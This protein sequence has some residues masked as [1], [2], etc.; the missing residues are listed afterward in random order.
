M[1]EKVHTKKELIAKLP[2]PILRDLDDK[3]QAVKKAKIDII[4][5]L[6]DDPT[7]TQTVYNI[8]VLTTWDVDAIH[9][10]MKRQTPL[11]FILT[12]SRSLIEKEAIQLATLIGQ[13]IRSIA[14]KLNKK[15]LV[16][17]RSDS[18]LRGHYPAEVAALEKGLGLINGV[19]FIVPAFFEGGRY[20]IQDVHYVEKGREMIPA[21]QT[22][23]AQ[24]KV[25]GFRSSNLREWVLEKTEEAV[26]PNQIKSLSLKELRNASMPDLITK[27][28]RFKPGEI[29]IVNA[30][31]YQDLKQATIAILSSVVHPVF[32]TAASFV[33]ALAAQPTKIFLKAED[34]SLSTNNGG[35]IVVGSY[36]PKSTYQ[37]A[38]LQENSS[39]I[40]IEIDVAKLLKGNISKAPIIAKKIS[41]QLQKGEDVVLFTSRQLHSAHSPEEN[42]IIGEKVSWYL[43]EVVANLSVAPRYILAK[44]GI[45]SSDIATRGLGVK[46]AMVQGQIIAG[47]PVWQLGKESKFPGLAYIVFPGNVGDEHSVSQVVENLA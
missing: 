45:T 41:S 14:E 35:L 44:G 46:R 23:F 47:V 43:T 20:T 27:I 18:T 30:A 16:I 25:F 4:I 32:R 19:R 40:S 28:D 15:C 10:E 3:L 38:Y 31:D 42:L 6:D 26:A 8:P 21:A 7:G 29:C 1:K 36:V 11:F 22:A 39:V 9:A 2:T 12:N 37:L 13:N 5:V 34:L 17:S 24:D 33:A